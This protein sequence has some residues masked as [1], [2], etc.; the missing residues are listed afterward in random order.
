V[1]GIGQNPPDAVFQIR[2]GFQVK[3]PTRA[4]TRPSKLVG[5]VGI[6][7]LELLIGALS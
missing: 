3:N 5:R 7:L 6:Y 1:A 2:E 4:A